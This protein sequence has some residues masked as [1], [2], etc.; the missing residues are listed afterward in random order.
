MAI[1]ITIP[2]SSNW[3]RVEFVTYLR[4]LPPKYGVECIIHRGMRGRIAM[5]KRDIVR[6]YEKSY[7]Y[8]SLKK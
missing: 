8:E 3:D 4:L 6:M 7:F 5:M 1:S 2:E